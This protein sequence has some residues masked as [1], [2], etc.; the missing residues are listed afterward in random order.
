M[1]G[2]PYGEPHCLITA[3][4]ALPGGETWSFGLRTNDY[5][6]GPL[7][8]FADWVGESYV[9]WWNA[10]VSSQPT[11]CTLGGVLVRKLNI[12]GVTIAQAEAGTDDPAVGAGANPT[13]PDQVAIV[14]SLQSATAGR[15]GKGRVYVPILRTSLDVNG[16]LAS[17]S[18][19]D[20]ADR[21]STLI[22]KLNGVTAQ[23]FPAPTPATFPHIC[24]QS[25]TSGLPGVRVIQVK[26][27]NVPDTM[28]RRRKKKVETYA[29]S[30]VAIA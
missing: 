21:F 6:P 27:G 24:I 14:H 1:P 26:V 8:A 29:T 30:D 10:I 13:F 17:V 15:H 19:N 3:H 23:D 18:T 22:E 28:R 2:A 5:N 7:Q 25:R 12:A 20:Y 11:G 4:G 9:E 16:N